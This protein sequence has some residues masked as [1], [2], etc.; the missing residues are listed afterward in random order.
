MYCACT[1]AVGWVLADAFFFVRR[2]GFRTGERSCS[3]TDELEE[4]DEVLTVS[5]E[6]AE[7]L[8]SVR[9]TGLL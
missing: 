6:D 8:D 1:S 9:P 2:R 3:S 7:T 5:Q 4:V